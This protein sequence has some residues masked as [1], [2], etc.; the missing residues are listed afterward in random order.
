M[1]PFP[2]GN[3]TVAN[4]N[5]AASAAGTGDVFF[6]PQGCQIV[7]IVTSG[8]ATVV[9]EVSADGN[10][11]VPGDLTMTTAG[12]YFSN[13][14]GLYGRFK[15]TAGGAGFVASAVVRRHE[16]AASA[17]VLAHATDEGAHGFGVYT[18]AQIEAF[19]AANRPTVP[20]NCSDCLSFAPG[21]AGGLVHWSPTLSSWRLVMGNT[22]ATTDWAK[23]CLDALTNAPQGSLQGGKISIL[24][25]RLG[26]ADLGAVQSGGTGVAATLST[27]NPSMPRVFTT[28]TTSTGFAKVFFS[29]PI[30]YLSS[31]TK[32]AVGVS[33][34]WFSSGMA[35]AHLM[36]GLSAT[37]PLSTRQ[38]LPTDFYG[39]ALDPGNILGALNAGL[40]ANWLAACRENSVNLTGTGATTVATAATEGNAQSA[41]V[42]LDGFT[43]KLYIDG[44]LVCTATAA[45]PAA[46]HL[47]MQITNDG[48]ATGSRP[49]FSKDLMAATYFGP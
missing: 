26:T 47:W 49:F 37:A 36:L 8:T 44:V 3:Q 40:S 17:A 15:A 4:F 24:K 42:V 11:W 12:T 35:G 46:L 9:L 28:G 7:L 43:L 25:S 1:K 29:R 38:T 34:A 13:V 48:T 5:L 21:G 18:V 20:V 16:A 6:I 22:I 41:L 23:F 14:R 31:S 45:T 39:L 33:A 2:V 19:T 27:N 32:S 10:V 30:G